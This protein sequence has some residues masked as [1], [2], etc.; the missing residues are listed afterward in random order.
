MT[1]H[2][3]ERADDELGPD[4]TPENAARWIARAGTSEA[5]QRL[6]EA[7]VDLFTRRDPHFDVD[8]FTRRVIGEL[9]FL[10]GPREQP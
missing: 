8:E 2:S 9:E 3:F 7:Y 6:F 10:Y 5:A 1:S 4:D